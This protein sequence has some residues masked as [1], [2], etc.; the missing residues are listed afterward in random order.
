[1]ITNRTRIYIE[2]FHKEQ[3]GG[4]QANYFRRG[5]R[6]TVE[7]VELK[8]SLKVSSII[9][10]TIHRWR[11]STTRLHHS[12]IRFYIISTSS[13]TYMTYSFKKITSQ[14][15]HRHYNRILCNRTGKLV[16]IQRRVWK[17]RYSCIE[18]V[19][20]LDPRILY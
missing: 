12:K 13:K 11:Q 18:A 1:M 20:S 6:T 8:K 3:I 4:R 14:T 19:S 2:E 5:H 15:H 10:A 16:M 17:Y 7:L 9:Y